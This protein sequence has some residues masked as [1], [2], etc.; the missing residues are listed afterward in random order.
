MNQIEQISY[1]LLDEEARDFLRAF[2]KE[3][4]SDLE[5]QVVDMRVGLSDGHTHS[6]GEIK[7]RLDITQDQLHKIARKVRRTLD[8]ATLPSEKLIVWRKP[9]NPDEVLAQCILDNGIV[10][11]N[12]AQF[13]IFEMEMTEDSS[14][15]LISR[16]NHLL[17][18]FRQSQ[19][20]GTIQKAL[21]FIH[22][23]SKE[24]F[25]L[26]S[27]SDGDHTMI[28]QIDK[29]NAR[30]KDMNIAPLKVC[31]ENPTVEKALLLALKQ[32]C[33][34]LVELALSGLGRVLRAKCAALSLRDFGYDN[35][36]SE[37]SE[38]LSLTIEELN[39]SVWTRNCLMRYG[40]RTVADI[41][42]MRE[43]ELKSIRFMNQKCISEIKWKIRELDLWLEDYE[44][45]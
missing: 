4:L 15:S 32:P 20:N 8:S 27:F 28:A 40:I 11:G 2:F 45:F 33:E 31:A 44:S 21:D 7:E 26:I 13:S 14:I 36:E 12:P 42:S 9:E 35:Y 6:L 38:S 3:S 17:A 34:E 29:K 10:L 1:D 43:S 25:E 39:L 22:F 23:T 41:V 18:S 5:Y 16:G 30:K 19:N 24:S 37:L